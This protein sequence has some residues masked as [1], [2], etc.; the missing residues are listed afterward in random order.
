MPPILCLGGTNVDL[1]NITQLGN[2]VIQIIA[3]TGATVTVTNNSGVTTDVSAARNPFRKCQLCN[4]QTLWLHRRC[5]VESS[6]PIRVSLTIESGAVGGAGFF[7]GF[8]TAPVIESPNGYDAS[9]CIPD[10]LPVILTATGF[11]N[12]QW[13][14]DGIVIPGASS[15]E[16]DVSS[17]GKYTVSGTLFGC[18]FSEQSFNVDI[19]LCPADIGIAKDVV[20]TSNVSG[21]L[22]DVDFQLVLTNY[23][24]TNPAPFLQIMDDLI[25]GLPAGATATLQVAPSIISGSFTREE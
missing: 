5:S 17:P 14:R 16:L 11:D 18:N 20:A 12:Y 25:S 23:S 15:N 6:R 19:T 4:V 2:A 13:R 22:F 24:P 1:P 21:S 7:S 10:N 3:E 9:T 8:T